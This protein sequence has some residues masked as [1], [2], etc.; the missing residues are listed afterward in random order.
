MLL[1]VVSRREKLYARLR[2]E[3]TELRHTLLANLRAV[4]NGRNTLFFTT[5]DGIPTAAGE[6]VLTRAREIVNL[7]RQLGEPES[8]LVATIVIGAF[9]QAN[10]R[11]NE[12]RLGPIRLAQDLLKRLGEA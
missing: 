7:A 11:D 8:E 1:L 9:E 4:A 10:D 2:Q 6:P 3:E 12:H 5:I